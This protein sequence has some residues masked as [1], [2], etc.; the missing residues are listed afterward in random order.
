MICGVSPDF[1]CCFSLKGPSKTLSYSIMDFEAQLGSSSS[2]VEAILYPTS[3][4]A[5]R[6]L[7]IILVHSNRNVAQGC[8]N[9]CMLHQTC[10]FPHEVFT[11]QIKWQHI[12]RKETVEYVRTGKMNGKRGRGRRRMN[13][14]DLNG[15]MATRGTWKDWIGWTNY[16][17][18]QK[19]QKI[20]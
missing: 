15:I 2:F 13:K 16:Q 5:Y 3:R 10:C 12:I 17:R 7:E 9:V 1:Q 8:P 4:F 14:I 20:Y 11:V 6:L 18:K 19:K